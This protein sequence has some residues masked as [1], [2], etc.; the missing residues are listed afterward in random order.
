MRMP[1]T[2]GVGSVPPEAALNGALKVIS[3]RATTLAHELDSANRQLQAFR[4]LAVAIEKCR[5]SG[6]VQSDPSGS[7]RQIQPDSSIANLPILVT[8]LDCSLVDFVNCFCSASNSVVS[9]IFGITCRLE[10]TSKRV[11]QL[12]QHLGTCRQSTSVAVE[13]IQKACERDI[14]SINRF[15]AASS[16]SRAHF[17]E[18]RANCV[19]AVSAQAA[20]LCASSSS[21]R[22]Q[23]QLSSQLLDQCL[24]RMRIVSGAEHSRV[25]EAIREEMAV[26]DDVERQIVIVSSQIER[27]QGC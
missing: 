5:L 27:L 23:A 20:E 18:A 24:A 16:D 3:D 14:T 17:E 2:V 10:S 9:A 11:Q 15:F 22:L 12:S 19:S 13:M 8:E 6:I 7:H 25:R 1:S 21:R 26:I 4:G